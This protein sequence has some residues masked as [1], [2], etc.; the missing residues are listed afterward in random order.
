MKPRTKLEK[1]VTELSGKLPAITKEQEDWGKE[2]VFDHLAYKCKDELWCSECGKMWVDA[3]NSELGITVLG[4][5]TECPYCHHRLDVK[6]SRKQKDHEGGY[7]SILQVKGGFQVIRHIYCMRSTYK[8][9]HPVH[10]DFTE[11]VQEWI[12]EDGKRTIIAR[13]MNMG[14]NGWIYGAPLSIKSEY[15]SSCWN[16]RGDIYA[17]WGELYPKKELLSE[18]KKRGLNRRFPDVNPS[19]LIRDLLKGSNDAELCLKTGQISMLKHMY[20]TGFS[21]LRYKP[22]FNICN[23]NHYIIKDA[24][25][26]EDYM[27][28]LSYF[29]KDLRNAHYVCPKNLKVEHDSLLEKKKICEAKLRQERDRIA[30]IR[31]REKLMKDIASFYERMKKFFGMKITDGNIVICPLESVTQ[32]YQEGKVM[33]HCVYSNGYYKRPDCLILSAKDIDGKRIET[34]EVNLKTLDIVQ[35]RAVCNGV[36]EYHNQIIKLVKKNMNL[37]R[38]KMTA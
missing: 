13:P 37:I 12:S 23:R 36:S 15:G 20:K 8:E 21:Q 34:I 14:G 30:A 32:F 38:Q 29:G 27:S 26:W 31:R 18:L 9:T 10:Y 24:S 3:S 2:H 6:V 16:Y 4:D 33:H 5:K 35:S 1:L 17:I 28:L 11:M 25:M 7:M 22:S 19:K